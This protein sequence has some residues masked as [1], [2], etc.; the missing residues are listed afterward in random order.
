[1]DIGKTGLQDGAII[2]GESRYL[3]YNL[4]TAGNYFGAAGFETN[5]IGK[6]HLGQRY[7]NQTPNARGYEYFYGILGGAVDSYTKRIGLLC[8]SADN[9]FT[10]V[11]SNNCQYLNGYDLQENGVVHY[12]TK[13]YLNDLLA[14]KA[15]ARIA[16]HD[17]RSKKGFLM[18]FHSNVPH[19]PLTVENKLKDLCSGV[20]PAT[21]A[22]QP[23]YRQIIC[24]MVASLDIDILRLLFALAMNDNMLKNT[25][26][27]Y[28]SDNG[29]F[30]PAGSNNIPLKSMKGAMYDGGVR[31]PSFMAGN[32]LAF[33]HQVTPVRDDWM[34]VT[35]V[36][37]TILSY[38]G[39]DIGQ[40]KVIGSPLDGHNMWPFLRSGLPLP[41]IRVPIVTAS[42]LLGYFSS[43]LTNILGRRYKYVINPTV[44]VFAALST[45]SGK[46]VPEGDFL[47]DLTADPYE[48]TDIKGNTDFMT[49]FALNISRL[50]IKLM[51]NTSIPSQVTKFPPV[52]DTPPNP[53]G[54]W[55]PLDSPYFKTAKCP[56]DNTSVAGMFSIGGRFMVPEIEDEYKYNFYVTSNLDL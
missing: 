5:F 38:A 51:M 19:T 1:M 27:V 12:D 44:L 18:H 23:Y 43:V 49:Q 24:G 22:F 35:D 53:F 50:E 7:M 47:Y 32:G 2:P 40:N 21:G 55:L 9:N 52:I 45:L 41:R 11:F 6:W 37:P 13:H 48:T 36:L 39:I 16:N 26:I 14:D 4:Q 56:G 17:F 20:S 42:P 10:G 54:C 15:V 3:P 29:G 34:F 25:L 31:V 33:A 30:T 46:Y 28:H 8:G